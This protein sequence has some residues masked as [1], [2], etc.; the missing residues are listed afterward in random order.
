MTPCV[1]YAVYL[2]AD[3]PLKLDISLMGHREFLIVH[4]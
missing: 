4:T 2:F 3:C 1:V